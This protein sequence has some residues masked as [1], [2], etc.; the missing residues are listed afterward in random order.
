MNTEAIPT[1]GKSPSKGAF[2]AA[3]SAVGSV[4]RQ[5]PAAYRCFRLYSLL[6]RQAALRFSLPSSAPFG[7][8]FWG[9]RLSSL[10]LGFI[11]A[12]ALANAI[13]NPVFS[14]KWFC[15]CRP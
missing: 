9:L 5:R 4:W 3:I 14:V 2:A 8:T 6:E 13:A 1:A 12:D 7:H 15:G 10:L 11:K